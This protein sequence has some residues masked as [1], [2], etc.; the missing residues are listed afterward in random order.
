[1]ASHKQSDTNRNEKKRINVITSLMMNIFVNNVALK[2]IMKFGSKFRTER[3][4]TWNK[5]LNYLEEHSVNAL[6]SPK[7]YK[8]RSL[9]VQSDPKVTVH[10]IIDSVLSGAQ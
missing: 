8:Y 7:R 3:Y 6:R 9:L 4:D 2:N 10:L 1:M 5:N